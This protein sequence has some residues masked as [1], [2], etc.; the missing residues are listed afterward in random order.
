M[1]IKVSVIIPVYNAEKYLKKA[2]NSA[3]NL[4]QVGEV[5]LVEDNSPDDALTLCIAL[6]EEFE[7][8]KLYQHPNGENRG[9]GASR[10]LGIEKA[11]FNYIAFLDADDWY[12]PNRFENAEKIFRDSKI[13]GVYEPVGT[14]FYN[15]Y[16]FFFGKTRSKKE[17]DKIVTSLKKNIDSKRLFDYLL[18]P[19]H[20]IIH[21]NGVTLKKSL[22]KKTGGFSHE[23]RLHQDTEFWIR[24]AFYGKLIAPETPEVV[25]LR[26]VHEQNRIKNKDY[27]SK[28]LLYKTI[29]EKYKDKKIS[30]S[31]KRI[32]FKRTILFNKDRQYKHKK[33]MLNYL[34]LFL[35]SF[36]YLSIF[37][38]NVFKKQ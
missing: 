15:D 17:G 29:F 12:L 14:Y 13:E 38:P 9:A 26:G 35:L 16:N 3:I 25:A 22:I 36:R 27:N 37:T 34:E 18:L 33:A 31:A 24:C 5:I 28:G 11:N 1:S 2:V 23:L 20:G 19:N 21:T 4:Q 10:N 7:K 8:V 6:Q 30:F 32:I